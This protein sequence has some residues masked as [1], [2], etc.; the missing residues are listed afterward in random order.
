MDIIEIAVILLVACL[1]LVSIGLGLGIGVLL[2]F[3]RRSTQTGTRAVANSEIPTENN[4]VASANAGNPQTMVTLLRGIKN[5]QIISGWREV[6]MSSMGLVVALVAIGIAAQNST[7]LTIS[8]YLL[9][10]AIALNVGVFIFL[11][12]RRVRGR[13]DTNNQENLQI[14]IWTKSSLIN[15][16]IPFER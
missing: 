7:V 13:K 6:S 15:P 4:G 2:M 16:T 3:R 1:V 14:D 8:L 11:I 12:V 9:A 5:D 10:F